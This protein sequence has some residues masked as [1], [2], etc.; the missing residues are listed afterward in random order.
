M[1]GGAAQQTIAAPRAAGL[2][3]ADE[4]LAMGRG[5]ELWEAEIRRLRATFLSSGA[6]AELARALVVAERQ[7]ARTLAARIR[8]TLAERL[9]GDDR[10]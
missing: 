2:A 4:A 3:L 8:G 7:G 9:A 1:I 5:A 10:G 6:E